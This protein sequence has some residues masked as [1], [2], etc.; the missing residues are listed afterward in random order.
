M[1]EC[2]KDAITLPMP[3]STSSSLWPALTLLAIGVL[4]LVCPSIIFAWAFVNLSSRQVI[5]AALIFTPIALVG[6]LIGLAI[7][8]L[9]FSFVYSRYKDL[10]SSDGAAASYQGSLYGQSARLPSPAVFIRHTLWSNIQKRRRQEQAAKYRVPIADSM[11]QLS[12]A[13]DIVIEL[14]L[15]D[16]VTSWVRA[17]TPE[18]VLQQRIEELIRILLIRLK[19]RTFDLD[20][21]QL[22]VT[23]LVPK[24]TAHV[25]DFRRAE[26]ALRGNSL[27]RSLTESDELDIMVAK[28]FRNGK[29]HSALT[30]STSTTATEEAYLRG[31]VHAILPT[32]LPMNEVQSGILNH[33]L[34]ELLVGAILLPVMKLL[35]DPDF[36]NQ[37][38]D[39]YIGKAIRE[40][41]MVKKLREAL[42]KHTDNMGTDP[43]AL[44]SPS[45]AYDGETDLYS[46]EDFL[47]MIKRCD[48]LLD[49][50]RIR[51]TIMTQMKKKKAL[52]ANRDKEDIVNGH[53]V[54]DISIYINRLDIARRRAEKRIEA[55]GGPA[56][57]KRRVREYASESKTSPSTI[58]LDTILANPSGLS[59]FMEFLDRR[60]SMNELQFWL[61]IDT[62]D[63]KS[64]LNITQEIEPED[65]IP[66][67]PES[68]PLSFKSSKKGRKGSVSSTLSSS[69]SRSKHGSQATTA[70]DIANTLRDDVRMIYDIYF[71]DSASRPVTIEH[72][73]VYDFRRFALIDHNNTGEDS[74]KGEK[75]KGVNNLG[76][77]YIRQRLLEAQQQVFEQM[78]LKV[79]PEFIKSN[80]YFKFLTSYQN[81]TP[82]PTNEEGFFGKS[83]QDPERTQQQSSPI[84]SGF[85]FSSTKKTSAQDNPKRSSTGSFLEIFGL[86]REKDKDAR[87]R[88]Q[89]RS[90]IPG[91]SS[92]DSRISSNSWLRPSTPLIPGD[93][94]STGGLLSSASTMEQSTFAPVQLSRSRSLSSIPHP[95]E[96]GPTYWK[97]GLE[98]GHDGVTS[99]IEEASAMGGFRSKSAQQ[100]DS[101]ELDQ[102]NYGDEEGIFDKEKG[103]L[104]KIP[105]LGERS[106]QNTAVIDAVEAVGAALSTIMENHANP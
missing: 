67:S 15:R 16:Y 97:E 105:G 40:Q 4:I 78:Q 65:Q 74:V 68:A 62:L 10:Q 39:L 66:E 45:S 29:L 91:S 83:R 59:Y 49:V 64:D 88:G 69:T 12:E 11:P 47:K 35:S 20:L 50:K 60:D 37:N 18:I 19:N 77:V 58:K 92:N 90:F 75:T 72:S 26:M 27:E 31:V 56:Y 23:R 52:I 36:W 9:G 82:E 5:I 2:E 13:I 93:R 79:Y 42:K 41:N 51:N 30:L 14:I 21:T 57:P 8:N 106:R 73:L 86:G 17:I 24:I 54:E 1:S 38:V 32:L 43:R 71:A 100:V 85:G 98:E 104:E 89:N 76:V 101:H 96:S 95:P 33:L 80:L 44:D 22:L 70:V 48:S 55:L 87:E 63:I 61:L 46:F 6:L 81:S 7:S 3:S 99:K 103:G 102:E 28:M 53:K 34:R 84:L 25:N 94:N